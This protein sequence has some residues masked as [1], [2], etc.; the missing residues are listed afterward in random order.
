MQNALTFSEANLRRGKR[1][2]LDR[3]TLSLPAGALCVVLG[4][5]GAGKTTL[6][7]AAT[8]ELPLASGLVQVLGE[9][10]AEL[11]WRASARLR[12]KI[13]V[14]PQLPEHAPASPLSVLELVEMSRSAM[15]PT[16][17][18]LPV[19]DAELCARW[20]KRFDLA[21]HASRPYASLSGGE[22]RKAHL[23]RIFAQEPEL[24][25]LDEP[26]GHLDLPSQDDLVRLLGSVWRE[27]G[28][29]IVIVTHDLRQMPPETTHVVLLAQGSL[30]AVGAPGDTV[31]DAN[32]SRLYGEEVNVLQ[33]AGRYLAIASGKELPHA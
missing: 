23:A 15:A 27:T 2:I 8:G 26:A 13:G 22:Q 11:G 20:L 9:N 5:N 18:R 12:R 4:P 30:L 16:S 10:L 31:T 24:I 7:R 1:L 25:L 28:T 33:H 19:Q 6:L 3:L 29:T 21:G 32:L 14:M 17:P